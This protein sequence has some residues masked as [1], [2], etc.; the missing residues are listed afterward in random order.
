MIY[1][2]IVYRGRWPWRSKCEGVRL[3]GPRTCARMG[4]GPWAL[5]LLQ[6]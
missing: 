1:I 2:I 3:A 6:S 4:T 5:A